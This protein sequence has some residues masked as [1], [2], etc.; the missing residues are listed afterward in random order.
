MRRAAQHRTFHWIS[1]SAHMT[2]DRTARSEQKKNTW[3]IDAAFFRSVQNSIES[4]PVSEAAWTVRVVFI[5]N[6]YCLILTKIEQ[7]NVLTNQLSNIEI[8]FVIV[9][10]SLERWLS[11]G[12]EYLTHVRIVLHSKKMGKRGIS[13]QL[14][15]MENFDNKPRDE[16]FFSQ[17]AITTDI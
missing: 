11:V 2:S 6:L 1:T 3:W 17:L 5:L 4:S 8:G 15:R 10:S 13:I 14:I 9:H 12:C 7:E 16:F